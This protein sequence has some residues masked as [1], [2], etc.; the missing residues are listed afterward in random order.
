VADQCCEYT[1][2]GL[3]INDE[4]EGTDRLALDESGGVTGLDGAP[5]RA[6]IDPKGQIDGSIVHPKLFA[7]RIIVFKGVVD[8]RTVEDRMTAAYRAA[9]MTFEA[10]VISALEG[11]LNTE[12]ALAWTPS[13]GSAQSIN[14]SY[15]I[16]GG[17]IVFSG[18]MIDPE[19]T[20]T[21]IASDPEI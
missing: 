6:Q 15:G 19:F 20:F 13:G 17:E 5:I 14:A 2:V 9:L 12:S 8:I 21:L 11:T 4:T 18:S 16:E 7:G 10:A 1:Y 3:T